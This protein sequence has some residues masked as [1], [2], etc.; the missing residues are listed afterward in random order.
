[1]RHIDTLSPSELYEES[2][3]RN[4]E[5]WIVQLE[6]NNRVSRILP[7]CATKPQYSMDRRDFSICTVIER[8]KTQWIMGKLDLFLVKSWQ[9]NYVDMELD[10]GEPATLKPYVNFFI[11]WDNLDNPLHDDGL[12]GQM[13]RKNYFVSQDKRWKNS[14]ILHSYC[15]KDVQWVLDVDNN[16]VPFIVGIEKYTFVGKAHPPFEEIVDMHEIDNG[17]VE[18]KIEQKH[19][20]IGDVYN[21]IHNPIS[22]ALLERSDV[23]FAQVHISGNHNARLGE[24]RVFRDFSINYETFGHFDD[25]T[26]NFISDMCNGKKLEPCTLQI[27]RYA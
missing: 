6:K 13:A 19:I 25:L 23:A 8:N 14:D 2:G 17:A 9:R 3:K 16:V 24:I 26:N 27:T 1:M 7:L 4:S 20:D 12:I 22:L 10:E 11:D 15:V 21:D 5:Q 18:V